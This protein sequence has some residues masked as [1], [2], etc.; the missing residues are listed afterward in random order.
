MIFIID[1]IVEYNKKN[2]NKQ[3]N[4]NKKRKNKKN[5][6]NI[7]MKNCSINVININK[8]KTIKGDKKKT[9]N[10]T[11]KKRPKRRNKK[12]NNKLNIYKAKEYDISTN[13]LSKIKTSKL[14]NSYII[15]INNNNKI[16][17]TEAFLDN[18]IMKYNDYE[19]NNLNFKD[20][21]LIDKRTYL[22]YYISLIKRKQKIVFAFYTTND[23]NS[24]IIKICLFFFSFSLFFTVNSLFFS[25][26]TMHKIYEDK[27]SF[28]FLF[29]IPQIIY[30][31]IISSFINFLVNMLSLTEK[32]II[33]LKSMNKNES[34]IKTQIIKCIKIKF[35]LFF[36]LVFSFLLL[37][38][39]YTSCFCAVYKNTQIHLIK[40]TLLSFV[41]SLLYPLGF[42]LLTGIFRIYS[43][44]APK[45]NKE[46]LYRISKLYS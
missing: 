36:V 29:Q 14:K 12:E 18:E 32:N 33:E 25:D 38:W 5:R 2:N 27:G 31:T 13:S 21:I 23:Y 20:A 43:L 34:K 39:Y 26:S 19:L 24:K 10:P 35:I 42:S 45:Q 41:L 22:Q 11:R 4:N 1:K 17:K 30:S 28:N 6:K 40:D 7:I 46:L 16:K 8:A 3:N 44:K 15:S 9:N 37:F